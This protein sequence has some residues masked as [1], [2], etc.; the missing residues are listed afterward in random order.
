MKL[1]LQIS[2]FFIKDFISILTSKHRFPCVPQEALAAPKPLM[3][4]SPCVTIISYLS[5]QLTCTAHTHLHRRHI[6]YAIKGGKLCL[7]VWSDRRERNK[8]EAQQILFLVNSKDQCLVHFTTEID[9]YVIFLFCI[10]LY[11]FV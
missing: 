8:R 5:T 2:R 6:K 3:W 1:R 4:L 11:K 10:V 9:I 7:V